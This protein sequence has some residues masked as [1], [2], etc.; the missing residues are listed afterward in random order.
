MRYEAAVMSPNQAMAQVNV[1]HKT[2]Y[3]VSNTAP[4]QATPDKLQE[5]ERERW[6]LV[7]AFKCPE[8]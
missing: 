5:R 7:R 1:F 2:L 6:L 4:S 3:D 8:N